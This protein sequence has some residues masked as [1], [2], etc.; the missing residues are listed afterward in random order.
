MRVEKERA[1]L[2]IPKSGIS[3]Y[4][5][6]QLRQLAPSFGQ[7]VTSAAELANLP[8]EIIP[9]T[10]SFMDV[11]DLVHDWLR[12]GRDFIYWD[13]GYLSRGGK[14]W[15][16]ATR[17]EH[18]RWHLNRFQ[19]ARIVPGRAIAAP[20]QPWRR[21]GRHIVL[22]APSKHYAEFHGI[23]DWVEQTRAEVR[24]HTDRAIIV[25]QKDS[26]APLQ[27]DLTSA[28]CL[29]THG[30]VAAV[31]AVV[32]GCPVVVD[33]SSAAALIGR[34]SLSDIEN[35][36]TPDR[37]PWLRSLAA[38]QFTFSEIAKGALWSREWD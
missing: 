15:L 6:E 37:E 30:S 9:C 1:A 18:F 4:K 8:A 38:H 7:V 11:R 28:H 27:R 23:G 17:N 29:V 35:L 3:V 19:M 26:R 25:R 12:T 16:P 2:Y 31:E 34:T 14:T 36:A 32:M 20:V 24:K 13:R 10:A 22:A 21:R 33:P 5:L